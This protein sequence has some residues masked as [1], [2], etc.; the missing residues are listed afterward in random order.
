[1]RRYLASTGQFEG[2]IGVAS[3]PGGTCTGAANQFN[4]GWCSGGTSI[5]NSTNTHGLD[6]IGATDSATGMYTDG[7]YLYVA[8]YLDQW[9]GYGSGGA[10]ISKYILGT[11]AFVGWKGLILLSPTGG[12]PG[13]NGATVGT[14][15]PG[16]CTGGQADGNYEAD[17]MDPIGSYPQLTGS[18][19]FLYFANQVFFRVDRIGK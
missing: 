13:C 1:M 4:G 14:F 7:N 15:T 11:G 12:D 19:G 8:N 3:T 18:G 2:W 5:V 10:L 16:W 9:N 17:V 6:E